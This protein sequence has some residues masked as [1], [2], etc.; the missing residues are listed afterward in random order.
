MPALKQLREKIDQID[1]AI[2]KKLAQRQKLSKQVG[3]VKIKSGKKV[4]D[5]AREKQQ[6]AAYEKLSAQYGLSPALTKRLFKI[7]ILQSRKLQQ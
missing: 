2:I 3:Q 1:A 7:I 5:P 4:F 6:N